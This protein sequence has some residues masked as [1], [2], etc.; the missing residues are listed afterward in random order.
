M[1]TFARD[2]SGGAALIFSIALP[3]LIIGV[4]A[5]VDISNLNAQQSRLRS[6]ADS[7]ALAA[8]REV[9]LGTSNVASIQRIAEAYVYSIVPPERLLGPPVVTTSMAPDRS[10]V[11]VSV[12][13]T[14]GSM[15][16]V[17]LLPL[18]DRVTSSSTARI[19]AGAPICMVALDNDRSDPALASTEQAR[20]TASGC[21]IYCNARG[22]EGMLAGPGAWH[23]VAMACSGG[24]VKGAARFSALPRLDCP[25][26]PDPLAARP[27]YATAGCTQT[28]LVVSGAA[29]TRL[30]PGVYCGGLTIRDE[31][32]VEL[33]PGVYFIKG[34]PFLVKDRARVSGV[35]VG[36]FLAGAE[37]EIRFIDA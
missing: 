32:S 28:K 17:N 3:T 2:C 6:V 15:L 11:Q 16:G 33:N 4:S 22:P 21:S 36:I 10:T 27:E 23:D 8:A 13:Q 9:R 18:P 29:L 24:G 1:C 35:N 26:L 12:S 30:S 34:G 25:Q 37:T 31:A 14:V 5:C 19:M 20:L 7:A